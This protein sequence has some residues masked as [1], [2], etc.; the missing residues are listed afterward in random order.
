[1]LSSSLEMRMTAMHAPQWALK[2][3]WLR[4]IFINSKT[5]YILII[6]NY[7]NLHIPPLAFCS[8]ANTF[9]REEGIQAMISI[10]SQINLLLPDWRVSSIHPS[11]HPS[12]IHPSILH[13]LSTSY[14]LSLCY[15]Q[16]LQ[17][18]WSWFLR[19]FWIC[20]GSRTQPGFLGSFM[21]SLNPRSK[22]LEKTRK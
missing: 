8:L 9:I 12:S 11:I 4:L 20:G 22:E 5:P 1:M 15:A 6:G 16:R 2:I 13:L 3:N 19:D 14:V 10:C 17:T 21:S 18:S 7:S